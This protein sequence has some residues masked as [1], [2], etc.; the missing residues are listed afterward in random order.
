MKALNNK[1]AGVDCAKKSENDGEKVKDDKKR[2]AQ[3][4]DAVN[5]AKEEGDSACA[6]AKSKDTAAAITELLKQQSEK[7]K[8]AIE[9]LAKKEADDAATKSDT[10]KATAA[11]KT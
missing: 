11:Q 4:L 7:T 10:I 6:G 3:M 8:Q 1:A 5:T 2:V 9:A